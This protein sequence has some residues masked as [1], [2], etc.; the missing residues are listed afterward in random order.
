MSD[1]EVGDYVA[2]MQMDCVPFNTDGEFTEPSTYDGMV[3]IVTGFKDNKVVFESPMK[4]L[5]GK[6]PI[7]SA[8]CS[9][10]IRLSP[11]DGKAYLDMVMGAD[12]LIIRVQRKKQMESEE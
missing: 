9:Q 8:P 3:G 5:W 2:V 12:D 7:D 4:L 1:I 11:E 6:P 10:L